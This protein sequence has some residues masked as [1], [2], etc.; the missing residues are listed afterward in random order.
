LYRVLHYHHLYFEL[1]IACLVSGKRGISSISCAISSHGGGGSGIGGLGVVD[2]GGRS[3]GGH[4]GGGIGVSS[5]GSSSV[6]HLGDRGSNSDGLLVNVWL[7]GDLDINIRLRWDL[8]VN[9]RFGRD[10]NINIRLRCDLLMHIR[11]SFDL[12]INIRLRWDLLVDIRLRWDLDINIGLGCGVEVSVGHRGVIG[13]TIDSSIDGGGRN[14]GGGSI[15][16]WDSS[17]SSWGTNNSTVGISRGSI[18]SSIGEASSIAVASVGNHLS[19]GHGGAQSDNS[20]LKVYI[21]ILLSNNSPFNN[22]QK[23]SF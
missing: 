5:S 14:H 10:L 13:G 1:S 18:S 22:L 12:D 15:S 6:G 3:S 16:S 19:L 9:I 8:L 2:K 7:G 4:G 20:D 21:S 11:L 17:I 23:P